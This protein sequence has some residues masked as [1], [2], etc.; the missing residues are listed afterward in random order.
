MKEI[1]FLITVDCDLRTSSVVTRNESLL[2]LIDLF[3]QHRVSGHVTWFLNENDFAITYSHPSFLKEVIQRGD[4]LG[5]HDHIDFLRGRWQYDPI[6]DFCSR[7][8]ESIRTW[9][10]EKGYSLP[11]SAH[12]FGCCFQHPEAYRALVDLG[13]RV[14]SDAVPGTRHCNH[15]NELSFDNTDIPVGILPYRHTPEAINDYKT[16]CGPML[17]IPFLKATLTSTFWPRFHRDTVD[18]WISGGREL[19]HETAAICFDFHPYEI[20]DA[21]KLE[22]DEESITCLSEIIILMRDEYGIQFTSIDECAA[23]FEVEPAPLSRE[24]N[25]KDGK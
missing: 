8:L 14:S 10:G 15:T 20:M 3:D 22:V 21:G 12:R 9:L 11:L 23:R 6:Y 4:T 18:A 17:Q 25:R 5:V 1:L 7:S 16:S 2:A 13:Y 19:G 24:K